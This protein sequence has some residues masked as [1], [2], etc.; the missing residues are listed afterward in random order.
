MLESAQN[1][2]VVSLEWD[3]TP[4]SVGIH[5]NVLRTTS[6]DTEKD[7]QEGS[8]LWDCLSTP[9]ENIADALEHPGDAL[10]KGILARSVT[11]A[12]WQTHHRIFAAKTWLLSTE[13]VRFIVARSGEP[14]DPPLVVSVTMLVK[15]PQRIETRLVGFTLDNGA[16]FG[17]SAIRAIA[18]EIDDELSASNRR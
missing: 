12:K 9:V 10:R 11:F 14:T 1:T 17:E 6:R 3:K 18:K 8:L 2:S 4:V 7:W 5:T 15:Q 13:R 16:D